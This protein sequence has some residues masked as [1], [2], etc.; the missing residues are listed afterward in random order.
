V[1]RVTEAPKRDD[2]AM[3][4][5]V[6]EAETRLLKAGIA[7]GKSHE[8]VDGNTVVL[9][10]ASFTV[11]AFRREIRASHADTI[12]KLETM[13]GNGGRLK[14]MMPLGIGGV[15]G[16]AVVGAREFLGRMGGG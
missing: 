14:R 4:A 3:E 15:I 8:T 12:S 16:A 2:D 1:H 5:V 9:A 6:R 13:L 7:G 11:R 10:V